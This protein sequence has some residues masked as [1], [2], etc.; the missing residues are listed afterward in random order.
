MSIDQDQRVLIE[1]ELRCEFSN[2]GVVGVVGGERMN[3][4]LKVP[5]AVAPA[6]IE[7]SSLCQVTCHSK[8]PSA[9]PGLS[10]G[11]QTAPCS[12][13][14]FLQS[15]FHSAWGSAKKETKSFFKE[16]DS[17]GYSRVG[18]GS[19]QVSTSSSWSP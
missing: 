9:P 5:G 18:V 1:E 12:Y 8:P 14:L 11:P 3:R 19:E 13:R 16:I 7:D 4:Q 6:G 17:D 15:F 2:T 10:P